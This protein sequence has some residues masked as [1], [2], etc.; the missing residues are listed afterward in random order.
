MVM[1]SRFWYT[2][3][4]GLI[5][6]ERLFELRLSAKNA[7]WAFKQGGVERGAGHY[8]AMAALHTAGLIAAPAEVWLLDR[9]FSPLLAG[10]CGLVLVATMALRYWAV[11]TLGPRWNTRVIVV[12]GLGPVTGGPYRYLR[13]PN[14]LAVI[15]E[16]A[17]LPLLH[18]AWITAISSSLLNAWLLRVRIGVEE[19]ALREFCNYDAQMGTKRRLL[20]G[21]EGP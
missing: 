9:P 15:L 16:L 5:A 17:A 21:G 20:P 4:V 14:Y 13:H 8:P 2:V 10:L 19:E 6:A 7:A 18:G 11:S 3:L 1:D 12:P